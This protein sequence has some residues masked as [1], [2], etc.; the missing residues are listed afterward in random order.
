MLAAVQL[1]DETLGNAG[2]VRDVGSDWVLTA[3][4]IA[5]KLTSAQATPEQY[6]RI[7][8]ACAQLPGEIDLLL[9]RVLAFAIR[10]G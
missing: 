7:S 8:G 1:D 3:E 5:I 4:S 6:F 9:W 10:H 2:K